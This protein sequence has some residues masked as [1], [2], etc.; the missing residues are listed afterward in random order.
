M[1]D[2]GDGRLGAEAL[3]YQHAFVADAGTASAMAR[4]SIF[5]KP[6]WRFTAGYVVVL[7]VL[8]YLS[9]S[10]TPHS[11]GY[12]IWASL[13]YAIVVTVFAAC[14]LA[15][16]I[17]IVVHRNARLRVFDGAVLRSGFSEDSFVTSNPVTSTRWSYE[18]VRFVVRGDFVI[19]RPRGG[20]WTIFPRALFPDEALAQ[21]RASNRQP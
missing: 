7:G 8:F 9:Y 10:G 17:F 4:A 18:G 21:I 13:F 2:T 11:V 20:A 5:P 12:R 3:G 6:P 14:L 19:L 15:G 1:D 16:F